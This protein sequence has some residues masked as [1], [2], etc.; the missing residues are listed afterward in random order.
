MFH[1]TDDDFDNSLLVEEKTRSFT[2]NRCYDY[3]IIGQKQQQSAAADGGGGMGTGGS[4]LFGTTTRK[5]YNSLPVQWLRDYSRHRHRRQIVND[6]PMIRQLMGDCQQR[7]RQRYKQQNQSD[8][9]RQQQQTTGAAIGNTTLVYSRQYRVY[10]FFH[11]PSH[12]VLSISYHLLVFVLVICCLILTILSTCA[13]YAPTIGPILAIMEKSTVLWFLSEFLVRLWSASCRRQYVG[14]L[15][16]L[17]Y[18]RQPSH[19]MDVCI[20]LLSVVVLSADTRHGS[21]VFA[22]SALRGFHRTF[23]MFQ[24]M[25]LRE[26]SVV[27]DEDLVHYQQQH[28]PWR[29]LWDVIGDQLHQLLIIVYV[30]LACILVLAYI[31]YV[32]ERDV[33]DSQ[34]TS[35]AESLWWSVITLSTV[36]YGDRV[37]VTWWGK[38]IA[39]LFAIIGV[40]L[41]ALPAGI[42]G[43]G[44]AI[45]VDKHAAE[46][47]KGKKRL[48]AIVLLQSMWRLQSTYR[49]SRASSAQLKTTGANRPTGQPFTTTAG[50]RSSTG[51]QLVDQFV[52]N[53]RFL[54]AKRKFRK[55]FPNSRGGRG[56]GGG[57]GG[58]GSSSGGNT[59][60]LDSDYSTYRCQRRQLETNLNSIHQK[61]N[62]LTDKS[63]AQKLFQDKCQSNLNHRLDQMDEIIG[64][65]DKQ[66]KQ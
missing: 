27:M 62:K 64:S 33:S 3:E 51:K 60:D 4:L 18:L 14:W 10:Q 30:Q 54:V 52:T 45:Q 9:C 40:S 47:L 32:V 42:I 56:G 50:S 66:F 22:V 17:R 20:I 61:V 11:R 37:H 49:C 57:S 1:Q 25:A 2:I 23:C 12:T 55:L 36:G 65:I 19:C 29:L 63:L 8:F 44:L 26:E 16:K 39:S 59:I 41:F 35:L 24:L 6:L 34:M 46:R 5:L 38:L 48:A 58:G 7:R 15:G 21:Q 28:Q 53:T 31:S 43:A 13:P